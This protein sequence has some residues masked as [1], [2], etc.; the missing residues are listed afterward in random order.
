MTQQST[1]NY[2]PWTNENFQ[3]HKTQYVNV[4]S[5]IIHNCQKLKT[6][7]HLENG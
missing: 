3:S 2:L 1:A 7:F 6:I 5:N 4:Y